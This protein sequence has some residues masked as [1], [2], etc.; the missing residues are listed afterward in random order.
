MFPPIIPN[1]MHSCFGFWCKAT[2]CTLCT[3]YTTSLSLNGDNGHH[4]GPLDVSYL[5]VFGDPDQ[6]C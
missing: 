4:K 5:P 1:P 2:R 3:T 6:F